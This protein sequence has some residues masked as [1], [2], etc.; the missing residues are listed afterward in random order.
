[1]TS[2]QH[3]I[4]GQ[5]EDHDASDTRREESGVTVE[6]RQEEL[7]ARTRTVEAGRV[8]L[9]TEVVEQ[10]ATLDVPLTHEE[11]TIERRPVDRRPADQPITDSS[12][13]ETLSVPVR[14]ERVAV[15]KQAVVYEEVSLGK[16]AV[17]ETHQ[18][19]DT[20]RKEVVDVDATGDVDVTRQ[21]QGNER[22]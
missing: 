1:M 15:D 10:Q 11:V 18:V 4:L 8:S 22:A 19:S 5:H 7:A 3:H 12:A 6:L 13:A 16:R 17:Q 9:G 14:E 20:V 21:G 2:Q